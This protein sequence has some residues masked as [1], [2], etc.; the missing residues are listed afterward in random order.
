[1]KF[2]WHNWEFISNKEV[3]PHVINQIVTWKCKKCG[4]YQVKIR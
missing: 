4:K 3:S 1:M 2:C